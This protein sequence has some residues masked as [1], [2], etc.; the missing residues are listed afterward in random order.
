MHILYVASSIPSP[1]EVRTSLFYYD[2]YSTNFS[3]LRNWNLNQNVS[4]L[5]DRAACNIIQILYDCVC[6]QPNFM[7]CEYVMNFT[8]RLLENKRNDTVYSKHF[9]SRSD[10]CSNGRCSISLSLLISN[11]SYTLILLADNTF[12]RSLTPTIPV[13]VFGK[14]N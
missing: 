3:L 4:W 8:L 12:H 9:S 13:T 10:I 11:E 14:Y 7:R 6:L 2:N 5:I 1:S